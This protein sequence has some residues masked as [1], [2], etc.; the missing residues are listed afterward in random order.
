MAH[1]QL[2]LVWFG[3]TDMNSRV[4]TTAIKR[5]CKQTEHNKKDCESSKRVQSFIPSWKIEF[6]GLVDTDN[7]M[8]CTVYRSHNAS[9]DFNKNWNLS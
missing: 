1:R 9:S 8:L 3:F 6:P 4:Q 5:E 2:G 7:G